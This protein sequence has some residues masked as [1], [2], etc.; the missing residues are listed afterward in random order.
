MKCLK[1][2]YSN[3]VKRH[4]C[5]TYMIL[6]KYRVA[7]YLKVKVYSMA[8]LQSFSQNVMVWICILR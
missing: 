8:S 7:L 5:G 1:C 3:I 6:A 2:I 4:S